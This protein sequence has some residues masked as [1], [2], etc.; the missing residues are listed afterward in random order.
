MILLP[1]RGF[2]PSEVAITWQTLIRE[3]HSVAFATPD[4]LPA[5][6]DSTMLSGEGLD[7]WGQIPGLRKVKILGLLRR[8]NA[9]ARSAYKKLQF[10]PA[11][12][13]PITYFEL[14]THAYDGLVLP[15]GHRARGMRQFL[16]EPLLQNF[17]ASFFDADKPVGA[18]CQGVVLAA[19]SRSVRTGKS[20]LYGR[21]STAP[22]SLEADVTRALRSPDDFCGVPKGTPHRFRKVSGL[23]RDSSRDSRAAWVTR[24]GKYV[25]ARWPG[26]VHCFAATFATVLAEGRTMTQPIAKVGNTDAETRRARAFRTPW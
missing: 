5:A 17:V 20:V 2:D 9:A 16:E 21:K 18:I 22:T 8:A 4:G 13:H 23:F 12:L 26:D 1:A 11:F 15:G 6:A 7:V 24:D 25:S 3:G 10:D 14:D 19:H